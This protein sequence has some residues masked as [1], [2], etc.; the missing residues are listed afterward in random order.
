MRHERSDAARLLHYD[1]MFAKVASDAANALRS[2]QLKNIGNGLDAK[3]KIRFDN[4][5]ATLRA[6]TDA[7]TQTRF[8]CWHSK[9]Y[10]QK[11]QKCHREWDSAA[12]YRN[13]SRSGENGVSRYEECLALLAQ[14]QLVK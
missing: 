10:W 7:A 2:T 1:T 13:D 12:W 14:L 8:L 3:P 6:K 9:F 5:A 11:C 4:V